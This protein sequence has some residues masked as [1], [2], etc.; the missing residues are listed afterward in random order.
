MDAKM[1]YHPT[2]RL[3]YTHT[4]LHLHTV[5]LLLLTHSLS[6]SPQSAPPSTIPPLDWCTT[7]RLTFEQGFDA[8]CSAG[9]PTATVSFQ[10]KGKPEP[11]SKEQAL[12]K[13]LAP[14]LAGKGLTNADRGAEVWLSLDP[15]DNLRARSS[16]VIW[17]IK[18]VTDKPGNWFGL[19]L[20]LQNLFVVFP[21]GHAP[22]CVFAHSQRPSG[23]Y[24][25]QALAGFQPKPG[26]WRQ[27]G[28]AWDSRSLALITDG[29]YA[30]VVPLKHPFA[31]GELSLTLVAAGWGGEDHD[32][33]ILDE[34]TVCNRLLAA[35]E[36]AAEYQR[37]KPK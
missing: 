7:L 25:G 24:T 29:T 36:V 3:P 30:T 6:A 12:E 17:W 14:G 19:M 1:T 16:T 18:T 26:E 11:L 13:L 21:A 33:V 9:S 35:E 8:E 37:L 4:S 27:L 31:E 34:V 10:R 2:P 15:A 23:E 5:T 20:H 32:V 22:G 28:V